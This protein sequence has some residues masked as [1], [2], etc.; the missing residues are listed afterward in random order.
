[1]GGIIWLAS[2]PKSGNT[3]MRAFIHNLLLDPERAADINQLDQF[4][5]GDGRKDWYGQVAGRPVDGMDR[6]ALA[7]LRPEVHRRMTGA[8]PDSVF[9]KTHS[10][11]ADDHGAPAITMECTAGAIYVV[12]NPLDVVLS[13]AHH[14][15][16]D[17]DDAIRLLGDAN[18]GAPEDPRNVPITLGTWSYH[19][20]SWTQQPDAGLH[21]VRY[22]DLLAAPEAHFGAIV[23]FL[24]L[25]ASAARLTK[26]IEFSSFEVLRRQEDEHGFRERSPLAA[27]FFRRGRAGHWREELSTERIDRVVAAHGEQMARFDYLP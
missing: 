2:Y 25:E 27:R 13:M 14:S 9:V 26:A 5:L 17:I 24:G 21:A 12:R 18:A 20:R 23:R 22:E 16:L 10:P 4:G 19:V 3:W 7:R 6:E 1:M 11:L 8:H 15:G